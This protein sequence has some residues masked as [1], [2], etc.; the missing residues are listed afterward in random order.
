MPLTATAVVAV[1][2]VAGEF[3]MRAYPGSPAEAYVSGRGISPATA[4][5]W[6]I[7]YA[8]PRNALL[9]HLAALGYGDGFLV[10]AG[11]VKSSER[12]G[13]QGRVYDVFRD[14]VMLPIL[15][16]A[17]EQVLG[18]G[19]R[20]IS[21]LDPSVPKY[22]N[23]GSTAAYKKGETFFG[24]ANVPAIRSAGEVFVVEGNFDALALH[25]AGV[26]NV[27][28]PCG[29]AFSDAQ[30]ALL[31]SFAPK[32]TLVFDADAAGVAATRKILLLPGA[33]AFDLGVITIPTRADG[34]KRDPDDVIRK[35]GLAGWE[36]LASSRQSRWDW[37]WSDTFAQFEAEFERD[38][39]KATVEWKD[40]WVSL[41]IANVGSSVEARR[42]LRPMEQ[43]LGMP[44]D[45]LI[46]EYRGLIG[47]PRPSKREAIR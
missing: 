11:L 2:A 45:M 7:G 8:P 23:S 32:A 22:A 46:D 3:F 38:D 16:E 33:E 40:A 17:G 10:D 27:V 12:D 42:L 21:D 34:S 47:Q 6:K 44:A 1:N 18:F 30:L 36:R 37:L 35:F 13:E 5:A 19:S 28:A 24:L 29:T 41:V 4:A 9:R 20:R 14:R 43:R 15:D 26:W 25:N 39:R 31:G